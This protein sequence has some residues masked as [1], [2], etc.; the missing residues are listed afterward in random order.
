MWRLIAI[1]AV[2]A[3]PAFGSSD[4]VKQLHLLALKTLNQLQK[5]SIVQNRE[6]CGVFMRG[7]A[8]VIQTSHIVTGLEATCAPPRDMLGTTTLATFHTHGP[9]SDLY[10]AEVPSLQDFQ[11][12]IQAGTYGYISTPGGRV[13]FIDPHRRVAKLLCGVG[14]VYADPSYDPKDTRQVSAR[15]TLEKLSNR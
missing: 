7:P 11:G 14:C 12:D 1:L 15:Y 13:W 4:D 6:L 8:G 10:D 3:G 9:H 5:P 2:L